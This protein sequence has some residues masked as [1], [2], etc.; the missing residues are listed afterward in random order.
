VE[1]AETTVK[2]LLCCEF[3]FIIKAMGQVYQCWWRICREVN[4][5]SLR[6]EYHMFYVLYP[7]VTYLLT[8]PR[9]LNIT[10]IIFHR[11]KLIMQQGSY[12]VRFLNLSISVHVCN[13]KIF[14]NTC[15]MYETET[16]LPLHAGRT[17]ARNN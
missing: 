5:F 8:P 9:I 12:V 16:F 15:L 2:R 17:V 13:V 14:N 3:L 7:S 1:V 6:L 11:K 10:V 4:V